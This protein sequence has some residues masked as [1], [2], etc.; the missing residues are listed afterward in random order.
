MTDPVCHIPPETVVDQPQPQNLPAIPPAQP[1]VQSLAQTV[2]AM[3][4]TIMILTGRQG[5][6][7]PQGVPG[8]PGQS[9]NAQSKKAQWTEA[10]R[11]TEQVKIYNPNDNTQFIEVERINSLTMKDS[12]TNQTWTWRR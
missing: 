2:N 3:R 9:G 10:S 5:V 12:A 11:Q 6:Q 8:K 1:N 7:G 4:Q